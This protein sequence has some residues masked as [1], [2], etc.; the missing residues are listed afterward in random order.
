MAHVEFEKTVRIHT[1]TT[2]LLFLSRGMDYTASASHTVL[3]C[4]EAFKTNIFKT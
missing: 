4:F 1:P 3:E 2:D